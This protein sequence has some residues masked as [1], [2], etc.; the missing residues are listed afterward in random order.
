MA[1]SLILAKKILS[2]LFMLFLG[3]LLVRLN[4]LKSEDSKSL[5]VLSLYLII[6]CLNLQAFQV[7]YNASVRN[8][9]LLA[10]IA[11][12]LVE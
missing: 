3:V 9:L 5:S 4:V 10:F 2:L 11:A 6:P 8:G 7:Q 1:V 12:L